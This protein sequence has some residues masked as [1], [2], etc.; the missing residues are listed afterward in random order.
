VSR[1]AAALHRLVRRHRDEPPG[2]WHGQP[3]LYARWRVGGGW[4]VGGNQT[5]QLTSVMFDGDRIHLEYQSKTS[6]AAL[7]QM[8][9][10]N[11]EVS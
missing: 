8:P 4:A 5:Y 2:V 1:F 6:L 11:P 7:H 10:I 3:R 9:G